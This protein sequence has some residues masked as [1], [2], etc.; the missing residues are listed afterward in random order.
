MNRPVFPADSPVQD[1]LL[2]H[3]LNHQDNRPLNLQGSLLPLHPVSLPQSPVDSRPPS[4]PAFL[5]A[6]RAVNRLRNQRHPL[7][8]Q[9]SVLQVSLQVSRL[10]N[11]QLLPQTNP[12]VNQLLS[13]PH[14]LLDNQLVTHHRL[15]HPE[16][17]LLNRLAFRLGF[18]QVSLP[19]LR[20]VCRLASPLLN[21][22]V[23]LLT[24]LLVNP[25]A[26]HPPILQANQPPALLDTLLVDHLIDLAVVPVVC[27]QHNQLGNHLR[28]HQCFLQPN[29][30]VSPLGFP[31]ASHL[32]SHQACPLEYHL[33]SLL[34]NRV[35]VHQVSLLQFRRHAHLRHPLLILPVS[36]RGNPLRTQQESHP[37]NPLQ[38]LLAIHPLNPQENLPD[39]LQVAQLISLRRHPR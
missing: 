39:N 6:H 28:S 24:N 20:Q 27:H 3:L 33:E 17:L 36:R 21:R 4:L 14:N 1:H 22:Q 34:V 23:S 25:V 2:C 12:V 5:Q 11:L 9:L 18:R 13:H 16:H 32:E 38:F 35:F 26:N 10:A 29:P 37:I 31:P 30:L 19:V 7:V 8:N 15:N